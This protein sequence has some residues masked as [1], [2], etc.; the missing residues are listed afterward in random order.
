[1]TR[2]RP[3]LP[4]VAAALLAACASPAS[5]PSSDPEPTPTPSPSIEPSVAPSDDPTPTVEPSAS[6]EPSATPAVT[7]PSTGGGFEVAANPAADALFLDRD[8]CEN[9]RDG[10]RLEYPDSW[11]TNTEYRDYP[12]CVWFSPSFYE[13]DGDAVPPEIAITVEWF[14][15]D[16]GRH[17]ADIVTTESGQVGGQN[18][19]RTEWDDDTYWYSIQL[20]PTPEEGPNLLFAT[21]AEMGGDYELNKAVLD[22]ILTTIEFIGTTQ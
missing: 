1:M 2:L 9:R 14:P 13:T 11:Y 6:A 15:G 7:P 20:G 3:I 22:R 5:S 19:I 18:A 12:P 4:I 21:S 16:I 10:Y 17:D 8:Q